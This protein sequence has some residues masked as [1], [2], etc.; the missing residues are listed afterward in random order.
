MT[1]TLVLASQSPRRQELLAQIGYAFSCKPANINEDIKENENAVDYVQRLAIEKAQATYH[2]IGAPQNNDVVVLGSDTSVV[3]NHCI[4]GKPA[5]LDE[6]I[7]QLQMLSGQTHQVLT[8]I[9]AVNLDRVLSKVVTTEVTFKTLTL[10]EITRYWHTGEPQD[11]AGS[12]GI[13]G[14]AGQ[15]VTNITG[16]Y[17][18]VVGLPLFET[19]Q[20]LSKF[21]V[22]T[23]IQLISKENI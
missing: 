7:T 11:K 1:N 4:L 9:A 20:L 5:N 8:S 10:D 13:Q 22:N 23:P 17:S 18:A 15:F 21:G 2:S 6:C 12:Y 3:Y 14:I 16:S 19:A